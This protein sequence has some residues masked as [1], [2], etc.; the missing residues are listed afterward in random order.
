MSPK[1][2]QLHPLVLWICL[3]GG[4]IALAAIGITLLVL[5]PN[6]MG[7]NDADYV[8]NSAFSFDEWEISTRNG[9][10]SFPEGGL[11]VEAY[12]N[13]RLAAFVIWGKAVLNPVDLQLDVSQLDNVQL[14][15]IFMSDKELLAARGST[16][17]RATDSPDGYQQ[18]AQL[19]ASEKRHL[20][21]LQVFGSERIYPFP[22]GVARAVF[23]SSE[24]E[25]HVFQDGMQV[26]LQGPDGKQS[27]RPAMTNRS[28]PSLLEGVLATALYGCCILILHIATY[29]ATLGKHPKQKP[30]FTSA[31]TLW[32]SMA[33]AIFYTLGAGLLTRLQLSPVVKITYDS[34]FLFFF[35]YSRSMGQLRPLPRPRSLLSHLGL[36][37][38]LGGL[39]V[40][41]G[42][43]APPRGLAPLA[44]GDLILLI[45]GGIIMALTQ[46]M[47]WRQLLLERLTQRLGE[48]RGL[49][50]AAAFQGALAF[51]LWLLNPFSTLGPLNTLVF[52]TLQA[53]WLGYTY[54]RTKNLVVLSTIS[55][56]LAIVPQLLLF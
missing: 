55:A 1:N 31:K 17:I 43:L 28:H 26:S 45:G 37:L 49:I 10:I 47:L 19:L 44:L 50:L 39:A 51:L 41:L 56:C 2:P 48:M 8:I 13:Q 27:V 22:A 3:L 11:A 21:L 15:V 20:P 9:I 40:F 38:L 29:F 30:V 34:L 54:Q 33:L 32:T 16:Y 5:V 36:G 25:R 46:E 7:I 42:Q 18:A 4:T 6:S 24:G 53:L 12:Q 14:T 23:F 52:V 35:S